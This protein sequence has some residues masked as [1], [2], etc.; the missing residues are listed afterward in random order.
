MCF[1]G[2][3]LEVRQDE[4]SGLTEWMFGPKIFHDSAEG[5]LEF[6]ACIPLFSCSE[7]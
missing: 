7:I 1:L 5:F 3:V 6:R 4:F 2:R